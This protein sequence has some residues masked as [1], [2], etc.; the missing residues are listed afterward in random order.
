M[1]LAQ[2]CAYCCKY[3]TSFAAAHQRATGLYYFPMKKC[4]GKF[5]GSHTSGCQTGGA[6][7]L[8]PTNSMIA[9]CAK[10]EKRL[11]ATCIPGRRITLSNDHFAKAQNSTGIKKLRH[12][13]YLSM[14][15][16]TK[17]E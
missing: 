12:P 1:F 4:I 6:T 15:M 11:L 2:S 10:S 14:P 13:L 9:P 17:I 7:S 3:P 8:A 5:G 16:T